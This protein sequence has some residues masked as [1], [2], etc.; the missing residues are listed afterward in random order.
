MVETH[1]AT[2]KSPR[3]WAE[4]R[5]S[6]CRAGRTS[7]W[8]FPRRQP[9]GIQ[10]HQQFFDRA[11]FVA[12]GVT[13]PKCSD[14]N[15]AANPITKPSASCLKTLGIFVLVQDLSRV[16]L[17]S[18]LTSEASHSGLTIRLQD[19]CPNR[20]LISSSVKGFSPARR[21]SI[22]RCRCNLCSSSSVQSTNA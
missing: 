5:R 1:R 8:G 21:V 13:E 14:G 15:R 11:Y 20:L 17:V 10:T 19:H 7:S 3:S 18:H 9:L 6:D 12:A 2:R 22:Q 4:G 16:A